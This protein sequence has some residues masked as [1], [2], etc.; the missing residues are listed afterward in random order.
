MVD[1]D[2]SMV[3]S[4]LT[5]EVI[6]DAYISA[7]SVHTPVVLTADFGNSQTAFL[8]LY[9]TITLMSASISL[10]WQNLPTRSRIIRI[11]L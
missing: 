8:A 7:L 5:M 2:S 10:Q 3:L 4:K 9:R 11:R 6:D 1:T